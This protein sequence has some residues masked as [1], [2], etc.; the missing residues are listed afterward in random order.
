MI[1]HIDQANLHSDGD[2]NIHRKQSLNA[3]QGA[4]NPRKRGLPGLFPLPLPLHQKG[5]VKGLVYRDCNDD[6][7][8]IALIVALTV[9]SL[10]IAL[11]SL[12][13]DMR[14]LNIDIGPGTV[15]IRSLT[16]RMGPVAVPMWRFHEFV[17]EEKNHT[18]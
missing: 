7:H 10:V 15:H 3:D 8:G 14:F 4:L 11:R 17:P 13:V 18:S 6:G 2:L 16:V 9:G 12:A 5:L 1:F